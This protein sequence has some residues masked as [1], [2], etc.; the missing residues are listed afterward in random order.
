MAQVI[1]SHQERI[2]RVADRIAVIEKGRICEEGSAV[3]ILPSLL[4]DA[5]CP[6][7]PAHGIGGEA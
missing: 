2:L 5:K 3:D 4:S 6:R 1:I 7:C